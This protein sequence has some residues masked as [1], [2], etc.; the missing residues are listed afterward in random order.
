MKKLTIILFLFLLNFSYSQF[1][2]G[3]EEVQLVLK[4]GDTLNGYG[5]L[6]DPKIRIKDSN[7]KN[8]KE[9]FYSEITSAT[10]TVYGGKKKSLK[11]T[12]KLVPLV[13]KAEDETNKRKRVIAELIFNKDKIK[14]YGV[15]YLGGGVGMGAGLGGQVS[16]S[17]IKTN[18]TGMS[19]NINDY[20]DFYCYFEGDKY[21]TL[22]YKYT[23]LRTFK[24]MATESFSRCEALVKKIKDEV[25]T[26][27]EIIEIGNFYNDN[28]N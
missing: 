12:F 26:K 25:F 21:P 24:M 20:M 5:N 16:V 14:I 22:I 10:F 4:N 15:Y 11:K 8:K 2:T 19:F 9:Y 23:S 27:K 7:K 18:S 17:N 28:C 6:F 13:F 3:Y 1:G